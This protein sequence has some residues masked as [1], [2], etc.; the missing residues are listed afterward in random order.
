M[1]AAEGEEEKV[2]IEKK[3]IN[4][5]RRLLFFCR[6]IFSFSRPQLFLQ[7]SFL[8][9]WAGNKKN[10]NIIGDPNKIKK[11]FVYEKMDKENGKKNN[12]PKQEK[13]S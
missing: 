7:H 11:I 1:Q 12:R 2:K 6:C 3:D 8:Y 5:T 4:Y 9:F 13:N 10:K